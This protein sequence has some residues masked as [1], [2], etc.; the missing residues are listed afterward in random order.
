MIKLVS[1]FLNDH[2]SQR[3]QYIYVDLFYD[4]KLLVVISTTSVS[5]FCPRDGL[6]AMAY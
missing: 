5:C 4:A 6:V 2:N 1:T 3:L